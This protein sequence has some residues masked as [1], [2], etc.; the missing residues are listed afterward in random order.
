MVSMNGPLAASLLSFG[1]APQVGRV[2][3]DV[4]IGHGYLE[5][6]SPVA[7]PCPNPR[8]TDGAVRCY[9]CASPATVPD[10]YPDGD[11]PAC[12]DH[13]IRCYHSCG[14]IA[15]SLEMVLDDQAEG[16]EQPL[17]DPCAEEEPAHTR[18]VLREQAIA[19]M[20]DLG[21]HLRDERKSE[22]A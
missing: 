17:C 16:E 11:G 2:D 10:V 1:T 8:C 21:D 12:E 22:A 6:S 20:A 13:A 18:R 19:R 3:C 5:D 7:H 15:R 4:C 9:D 14:R